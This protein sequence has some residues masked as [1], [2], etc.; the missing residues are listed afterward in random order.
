MD[1]ASASTSAS[2]STMM[3]PNKFHL[4]NLFP[5]PKHLFGS[6][7]KKCSFRPDRCDKYSGCCDYTT[8]DA[9]K[10]AA[11]CYICMKAEWERMFKLGTKQEPAY[12]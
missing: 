1:S 11:F 5:F 2:D 4:L 7:S 6:K 8:T 10:N 3:I 9:P 12:L